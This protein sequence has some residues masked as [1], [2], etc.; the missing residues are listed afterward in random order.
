MAP[1]CWGVL[2]PWSAGAVLGC[3]GVPGCQGAPTAPWCWEVPGGG[4]QGARGTPGI[5][6][7]PTSSPLQVLRYFDY[8]FTGVFTFEMVIKVSGGGCPRGGAPPGTPSPPPT[9]PPADGGFGAG[10]SPRC[11]FPGPVE[12]PGLHRG[13]RGAGGLRLHVSPP[14]RGH[15]GL[16]GASWGVPG[17]GGHTWVPPCSGDGSGTREGNRGMVGRGWRWWG[18]ASLGASQWGCPSPPTPALLGSIPWP[19]SRSLPTHRVRCPAVRA[20]L[21]RLTSVLG[22]LPPCCVVLSPS[23][24]PCALAAPPRCP[25]AGSGPGAEQPPQCGIP[26]AVNRAGVN[27]K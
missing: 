20:L 6:P 14:P 26:R 21:C 22:R 12:H 5:S 24:C 4:S 23:Q 15:G 9:L 13:Q 7:H 2:Q 17:G 16:L 18:L 11:L 3:Q 1:G 27:P 19:H 25:W 8:V 10:A